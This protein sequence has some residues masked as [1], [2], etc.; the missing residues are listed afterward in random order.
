M[1]AV[2]ILAL[3]A[4][5]LVS[6]TVLEDWRDQRN[7][8]GVKWRGKWEGREEE[9]VWREIINIKDIQKSH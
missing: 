9:E 1:L 6:T 2:L 4:A 7:G 5:K 8:G 3:T